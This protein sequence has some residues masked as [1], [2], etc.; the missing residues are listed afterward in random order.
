MLITLPPIL[1][2]LLSAEETYSNAQMV[3]TSHRRAGILDHQVRR[4]SGLIGRAPTL[5]LP[6]V[7]LTIDLTTTLALLVLGKNFFFQVSL[8]MC[9]VQHYLRNCCCFLLHNLVA[10]SPCRSLDFL[11]FLSSESQYINTHIQYSAFAFGPPYPFFEIPQ[12]PSSPSPSASPSSYKQAPSE[13]PQVL[14]QM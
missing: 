8:L 1:I 9:I 6:R 2:P 5:L 12:A 10:S 11:S 7:G 4:P 13:Y 3:L 14:Y